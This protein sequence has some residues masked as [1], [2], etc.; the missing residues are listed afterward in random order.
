MTIINERDTA[1]LANTN[2]NIPQLGEQWEIIYKESCTTYS[3]AL[4]QLYPVQEGKYTVVDDL[5][6]IYLTHWG[7]G[8]H[9]YIYIH[10]YTYTYPY[11][12]VCV[13]VFVYGLADHW[14]F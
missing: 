13:W 6:S 2:P 7:P 9:I 1:W 3:G 12:C 5:S 4:A 14:L 10:T 8:M 11:M